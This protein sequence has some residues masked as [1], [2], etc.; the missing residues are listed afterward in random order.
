VS[1]DIV[2][3]PGD[4]RTPKGVAQRRIGERSSRRFHDMLLVPT[5]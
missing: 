3:F 5:P 2:G 4:A 1:V